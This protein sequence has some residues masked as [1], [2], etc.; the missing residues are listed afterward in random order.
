MA[1]E[2]INTQNIFLD[3][4][5]III[6]YIIDVVTRILLESHNL[7]LGTDDVRLIREIQDPIDQQGYLVF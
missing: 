7:F 6:D 4:L 3:F 5:L 1:F 2:T